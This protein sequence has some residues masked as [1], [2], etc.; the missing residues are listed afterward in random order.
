MTIAAVPWSRSAHNHAIPTVTVRPAQPTD[1]DLLY[2]MH[3]RLSPESI[4]ARYLYYRHPQLAEFATIT[5]LPPA[6]GA[7]VVATMRDRDTQVVGM[8]YYLRDST[9][10]ASTPELGMVVEDRYQGLGI[11]RLLWFTLAQEAR[12]QQIHHLRVLFHPSNYR[13]LRMI[14][15]SGY[16]FVP[17][18]DAGLNDF[19]L[20]IGQPSS[21]SRYPMAG[22]QSAV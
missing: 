10:P 11:G 4:Y 7:A 13:V 21:D 12:A 17:G 22:H 9:Q 16:R 3:E 20:F 19:T 14:Q 18:T 1:A 8:A 6:R 2:A 5:V 15:S